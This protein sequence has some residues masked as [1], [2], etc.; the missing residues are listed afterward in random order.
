MQADAITVK[1]PKGTLK[2]AAPA[3][4]DVAINGGEVQLLGE[5][6]ERH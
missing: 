1:G 4:V 2:L 5:E 3:G 6:P